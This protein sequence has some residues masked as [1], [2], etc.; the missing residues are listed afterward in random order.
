MA[1]LGSSICNLQRLEA[2]GPGAHTSVGRYHSGYT[3]AVHCC[4]RNC[5]HKLSINVI[6]AAGCLSV[7]LHQAGIMPLSMDHQKALIRQPALLSRVL[8]QVLYMSSLGL[9]L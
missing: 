9:W 5:I 4:A 6:Q 8:Q 3:P 7:M 2:L 1:W